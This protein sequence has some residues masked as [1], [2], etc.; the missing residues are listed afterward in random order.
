MR[1][2]HGYAVL[3]HPDCKVERDTCRCAHHGGIFHVAPGK[4]AADVGYLCPNCG[5]VIC[6][7]CA[8]LMR[9]GQPCVPLEELLRA[10]ERQH[11]K[12]RAVA[13]YGMT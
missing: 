2:A 5:D 11:E 3:T 8:R 1:N 13:E 9:A 12:S 4:S 7:A 6:P 10:I